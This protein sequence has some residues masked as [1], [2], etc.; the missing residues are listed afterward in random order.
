MSGNN[1]KDPFPMTSEAAKKLMTSNF[2]NSND[3]KESATTTDVN[4]STSKRYSD[5]ERGTLTGRSRKSSKYLND[6]DDSDDDD[7]DEEEDE[8]GLRLRLR[9]LLSLLFLFSTLLLLR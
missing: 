3:W 2:E 7:D 4:V 1:E 9:L 6:G 5:A 8:E